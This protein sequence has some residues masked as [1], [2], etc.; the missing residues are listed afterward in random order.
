MKKLFVLLNLLF[1]VAVLFAQ[2][3]IMVKGKVTDSANG[4]P[5]PGVSILEK[6]TTNNGTITDF[7]GNYSIQ[8]SGKGTLVFSFI[9][10]KT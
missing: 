9:G 2:N 1:S 5:L 4:D 8:V 7:D 10:M 3:P 6:G